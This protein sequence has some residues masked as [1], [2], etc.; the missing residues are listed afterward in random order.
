MFFL[1]LLF[2]SLTLVNCF[3]GGC[4]SKVHPINQVEDTESDDRPR[5]EGGRFGELDIDLTDIVKELARAKKR[6]AH[7]L[8]VPFKTLYFLKRH[9]NEFKMYGKGCCA[10]W[11]L[12]DLCDFLHYKYPIYDD[13]LRLIFEQ[14]GLKFESFQSDI[15]ENLSNA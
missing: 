9:I 2:C 6:D 14:N 8:F 1:K 5:V 3:A 7:F 4:M 15:E 12:T 11:I 13:H 10:E